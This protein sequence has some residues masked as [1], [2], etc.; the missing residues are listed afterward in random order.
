MMQRGRLIAIGALLL[1]SA[2]NGLQAQLFKAL[3]S[4]NSG[5]TFRNDITETESMNILADFNL[6]NGGGVGIGDLDGDGRQDIVFTSTNRGIAMYGNLGRLQFEDRTQA[7]GLV[8]D[9]TLINTG[10]LVADITGDGLLDVLISR[11]YNPNI[12]FVNNGSGRF[13]RDT[14]SPL[15]ISMYTTHAAQIDYDRDG[16]LD[17]FFV[18]SGEPRR[19]GYLNPGRAD[20][21]FRNDGG[22]AYAD[23][24]SLCGLSDKGYG[25]SAAIGDVNDDGWPDI[26]VSNDFEERDILWINQK[27]GT[28][29]NKA[30]QQ[31][32]Y[33]SWASMGSDIADVN[34]DGMLD[35]V[36][37]DMLPRSNYRRQTQ[38]GGMSIYGPFFDSLQRVQNC[39][40]LNRGNGNFV[41]IGHLAGISATDWS[42]CVLA[43]DFDLD[44]G[45]DLFV[46][47]GTKRDI[48]D[49][50]YAYNLRST[51]ITS[52]KEASM[53][54]PS[55]KLPNFLFMSTGGLRFRLA[56]E[57]T[58]VNRPHVSNGAAY[59]DLDDDGDLDLVVNNTDDEA[60]LL[61]N[62]T[63]DGGA[64][65]KSSRWVG[66]QLSTGGNRQGIGA[67]A[68]VHVSG[69]TVVREIYGSRGFQSTSDTRILLALGVGESADSVV[70]DWPDGRRTWHGAM[71]PGRYHRIEQQPMGTPT[72]DFFERAQSS[73]D[74]SVSR[75]VR[76][77]FN[78]VGDSVFPFVHRENAFD[79]FKRERL[80]PYRYSKD[81]PR[82]T[83]GDVNR[84][85]LEDV[86]IGG[87]KYQ[88]TQCFLQQRG[89]TFQAASC[90]LDDMT[91][92]EDVDVLLFDVD[93]D[94]D[95]DL[96]VVTGGAEFA[97]GDEELADRLY[98]NNGKGQFMRSAALPDARDAG[99]CVVAADFD[100]DNDVDLFVG[101]RIV[102]GKFPSGARSVLY[103]NDK[104]V[105]RDV[106]DQIAKGLSTI[107]MTS[108]AVWADIDGDKDPDLVVVGEW[109]TPSVW[110]NTKGTF[111]NVTSSVIPAALRGW[112]QCVRAADIDRDGD[113]DLLLG[114]LGLNCRF[115]P[116]P[117]RPIRCRTA[118]VDDNGSLD[119]FITKDIEG[120]EVPLRGRQV[121]I[122]HMPTMTRTFTTFDSYAKAS[123]DDVLAGRDTTSMSSMLVET[124]ASGV[125]KNSNG[126]FA[127]QPFN[128][129]AQ[130]AP[131]TEMLVDDLDG[132]GNGDVII[133]GNL[134]TADGEVIGYDGGMG[135]VLRNQG[136]GV[137][138]PMTSKES[139]F[140]LFGEGRDLGIIRSGP[141]R[142]LIA[143]RN[144]AA[145]RLFAL[146]DGK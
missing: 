52:L 24:T 104:G 11:R 43:A 73:P 106:T 41:E 47:N 135:L 114:N 64:D 36:T 40:F 50:D 58:D 139:G 91:S 134:R 137:L 71:V 31:L 12:L 30:Q 102:P 117:G 74:T 120:V 66:L 51:G 45:L 3:P 19:S 129:L 13:H 118:D 107:G 37:L 142:L 39:F 5:V 33:M 57:E 105:L 108:S 49:Q 76:P 56:S 82:M 23:V 140:V 72:I 18:N 1:L 94:R 127:F 97:D 6:F 62:T 9:D 113:Q 59:A 54:M 2:A 8:V 133:A 84:D 130:V 79:D 83:I 85:G 15:A 93:N 123:I 34:G 14:A 90:G 111:E 131:I 17:L 35:V 80:L 27:N 128:D 26:F 32:P 4:S 112:W 48:G 67:R 38:I 42:W 132:D 69:R 53:K 29:T 98:L 103:R 138:K 146:P 100:N 109:M 116:E 10:V 145:A 75:S 65:D 143:T 95:L 70:I 16:D 125:L 25:L 77:L 68:Q 21:L 7:S 119:Q 144:S 99:S 46:T 88:P 86:I 89:G 110:R 20:R 115:V 96:Y 136:R 78:E 60:S 92:A 81:G 124:F 61:I 87:A 28:F 22:G 141:R 122:Q 126:S 55:S 121:M 44:G 101:G 63:C